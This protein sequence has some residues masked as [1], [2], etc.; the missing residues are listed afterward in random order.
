MITIQKM[1]MELL[2]CKL[3][4]N[5]LYFL[6][7]FKSSNCRINRNFKTLIKMKMLKILKSQNPFN[8]I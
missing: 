8:T 2:T 4:E 3:M 5:I 6:Y 7:K 1:M